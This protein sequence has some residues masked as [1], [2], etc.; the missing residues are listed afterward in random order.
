LPQ[1][2]HPRESF[3]RRLTECHG[4]DVAIRLAPLLCSASGCDNGSLWQ[5]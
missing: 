5:S 3:M 4:A 2:A 1:P